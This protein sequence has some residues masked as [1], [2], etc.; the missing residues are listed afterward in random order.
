[1]TA[2]KPVRGDVQKKVTPW[3]NAAGAV[4]ELFPKQ[5][6]LSVVPGCGQASTSSSGLILVATLLH[7]APNLGGMCVKCRHTQ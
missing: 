5:S 1:M 3:S 7:K 2:S 4:N 6:P